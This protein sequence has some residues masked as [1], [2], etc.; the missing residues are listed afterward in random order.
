MVR[1]A[2]DAR[3]YRIVVRG[4]CG[5]LLAS[6]IANVQVVS[7]QNGDTCVVALVRDDPELWGLLEQLRDLAMHVVSLQD[8]DHDSSEAAAS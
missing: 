3:R 7:S 5:R 4:E 6:L 2:G 8:L 1:P